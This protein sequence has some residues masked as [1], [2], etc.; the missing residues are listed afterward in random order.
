[1]ARSALRRWRLAPAL[2]LL[3]CGAGGL[4]A[5]VEGCTPEIG[6]KCILSTDCST[7]GDRLCDTSQVGGYCTQFNCRKNSCPN[8]AHCILFNASIPGCGYDDRAGGFGSRIARSFCVAHCETDSDC[9]SG[10]M[11]ADPRRAPWS[12]RVQD[13]NQDARGCLVIPPELIVDGGVDLDAAIASPGA[14]APICSSIL[15]PP[16]IEAG[17]PGIY[18][19]A[20]PVVPDAEAPADAGADAADAGDA[21]DADAG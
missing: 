2:G 5:G 14:P 17:A 3:V 10:Y 4:A 12:G 18:D 16:A 11:C 7:R 13:D 15:T 6:D 1:V 9:R 19:G 8:D 21:G 20:A